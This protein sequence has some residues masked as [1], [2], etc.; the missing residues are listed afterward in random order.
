MYLCT[1]TYIH[2]YTHTHTQKRP[3][4]STMNTKTNQ[5][6]TVAVFFM[7]F[8]FLP[9]GLILR[10]NATFVLP[11]GWENANNNNNNNNT[12]KSLYKEDVRYT[13]RGWYIFLFPFSSRCV[14]IYKYKYIDI[15]LYTTTFSSQ[16]NVHIYI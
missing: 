4:T 15:Y 16:S 5:L 10:I 7:F 13:R 11:W 8:H 9:S 12:S 2:T 3:H 1:H 14:D 6:H